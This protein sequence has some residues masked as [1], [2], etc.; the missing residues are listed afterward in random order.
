MRSAK[1]LRALAFVALLVMPLIAGI[2]PTSAQSPT[3]T[4]VPKPTCQANTKTVNYWHGLTGPDGNFL[5]KM[6]NDY[7][8]SNKD[9]LC[10][11]LS[12]YSWDVFFTKWLSAI[13][14]GNPPDVVTYHINEMPQYATLGAVV[15]ID[16]LAKQVGIDMSVYPDVQQKLSVY[17]G[18]LMGVP[19]DVHPI[20][21]YINTDM[22][23]AA[24]L[25]PTKPPTDKAT[26][27]DW[28][29]KLTKADGS[30]YG[31]C[32]G[33]AN[34]QSFRVWYGWLAQNDAKFISDD[35]KT[36]TINSPAAAETLQFG[37]DLIAKYKVAAPNSQNPDVD[38]QNKKCAIHFQG[39]WWITGYTG[40]QGLN[41][42]TAPQ[43]VIFKHPGVWASDHFF[44]ISKQDNKENQLNAMKFVKW[45]GDHAATWGMAGQVPANK[46]ARE[47]KEFTS[48]DIYPYIKAFIDEVPYT[49]LTPVIPQ[50]TEI[51]AEGVQTPLVIN[52]QAAFLGQKDVQTALKDMQEGIQA[53]LDKGS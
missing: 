42:I 44:G 3:A 8:S 26:F 47:S 25:D 12:N 15:P 48:S 29:Q 33:A 14:A 40:T 51:F 10:V 36:I 2:T 21:M 11:A 22:A 31:V 34:V 18:K 16:D 28:A 4:P 23:K 43:P 17:N 53:V 5:T 6:V 1:L 50:S 9:G 13:A 35:L 46:T 32:F 37:R 52:Y 41:F 30:Q 49:S 38:F 20:A 7:N 24:G 27:L 45:M 19:L 39:P